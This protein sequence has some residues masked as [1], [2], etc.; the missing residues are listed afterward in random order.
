MDLPRGAEGVEPRTVRVLVVEDDEEDFLLT[1]DHLRGQ[2]RTRFDVELAAS[3][4]EAVARIGANEHDI[5]LVDHR[6]GHRTGLDLVREAFRGEGRAP[7]IMLTGF[8]DYEVDLEANMLG[9]TDFLLKGELT[10]TVLER[11]IRYALRHHSVLRELQQTQDRYALAVRGAN[12]GIWDWDL[13]AGTI[14][15]APRWKAFLGF[16]DEDIGD[17][18]AEWLE[19]VHPDDLPQLKRQI[20]SHVEGETPH[21][22]SEHRAMHA[23]GTYRWMFARGVAVRDREG[24]AIRIAGSISDI[25]G[26]KRAEERLVHD[27]L[28]DPLT[29]LPNRAMF[30]DHLE[31]SL[32][33]GRRAPEYRCAVLFLDLNRFKLV[34]DAYSHAAGDQLLVAL[35][36]R[37]VTSMRPGDTV[38]RLGGDEFTILLDGIARPEDAKG[39][40]DRIHKLLEEPF[41]V[42]GRE[43]VVTTAIG[44]AISGEGATA[45]ELMRDADIAMYE[46]KRGHGRS[47]EIFSAGMRR[48]VVSQL[49]LERELRVALEG[50]HLRVYYQPIVAVADGRL[51]GLEALARWPADAETQIA[52]SEFIPVAE[53]TGMIRDIGRSVL[54]TA[55]ADLADWRSRGVV[56]DSVSVSVNVSGREL[57]D[58][59]LLAEVR[60]A[61]QAREL[62]PSV[63]RLEITE[64]TIMREPERMPAVLDRL[65]RLGIGLHIDDFGTGYSSLTFLRHFSGRTLKVDRS[66]ISALGQDAGSEAI[67]RTI[68]ALAGSLNLDVI[69]EGVEDADQLS[70]LRSF[71]CQF[72]QGFI[73]ARPMAAAEA[74]PLLRDWPP[75]DADLAGQQ[76]E[77]G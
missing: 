24:R 11:S 3:F 51:V 49:E 2:D 41:A 57:G 9:V 4:A 54:E 76:R 34:N 31:L 7:V 33:R 46:V 15:Y 30:L 37:L 62:P 64:S 14:Y 5:Y 32:R 40:A 58:P 10:P 50:G 38:A 77:A 6:L 53:S 43:L 70:A 23:D 22:A 74:E 45:D 66:F 20:E 18:P 56:G 65:E 16:E 55:L 8:D 47:A 67:V 26:R 17:S 44:I 63:L 60:A 19:R 68:I 59:Q 61:L 75:D 71:G 52:P 73:F 29:G 48:R 28:H 42:E 39:V 69:A 12:D 72:A 35:A 27:A 1:R 13:E 25:T 36:R 21:L